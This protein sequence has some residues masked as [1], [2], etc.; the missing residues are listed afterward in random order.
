[1]T[2]RNEIQSRRKLAN[3]I[4]FARECSRDSWQPNELTRAQRKEMRRISRE[5]IEDARYWR[6]QLQQPA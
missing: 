1:M 2:H 3:C 5:A 4:M 6:A